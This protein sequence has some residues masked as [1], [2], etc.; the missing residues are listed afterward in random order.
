MRALVLNLVL[1]LVWA[2]FIGEITPSK[3]AVGF[4]FGYLLMWWLRR[5]VGRTT[6]FEKVPQ[7]LSF[8]LFFIKEFVISNVRVARD[9]ISLKRNSRPGIVAVPLDIRSDFEITLLAT[10]LALTP[11][12]F[13]MDVSNDRKTMYIHAMFVTDPDLLRKSIKDGLER[14]IMELFR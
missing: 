1:A 3:L 10:L 12:T 8:V 13:A 11:G 4:I 6:Y 7:I 2:G 5:L 9:V 14:R